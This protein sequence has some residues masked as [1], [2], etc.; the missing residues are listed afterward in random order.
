[1]VDLASRSPA[2][3]HEIIK[4]ARPLLGI[5]QTPPALKGKESGPK[6]SS[7]RVSV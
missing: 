3:N 2:E 7:L 6:I 1:M 5:G 4:Q